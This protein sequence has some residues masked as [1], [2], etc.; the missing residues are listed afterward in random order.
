[1][2]TGRRGTSAGEDETALGIQTKK[3]LSAGED[4]TTLKEI[5]QKRD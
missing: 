4:E 3:G 5:R 1:M 2:M